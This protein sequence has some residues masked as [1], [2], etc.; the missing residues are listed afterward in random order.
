MLELRLRLTFPADKDSIDRISD[1]TLR[2]L[3]QYSAIIDN[4][5]KDRHFPTSPGHTLS[6]GQMREKLLNPPPELM[7]DVKRSNPNADFLLSEFP[8]LVSG[9]LKLA[10]PVYT[11]WGAC[12]DVAILEKMRLAPLSTMSGTQSSAPS[13]TP[14][15]YSIPNLAVISEGQTRCIVLGGL[16]LRLF[17]LGGS[18]VGH[19]M[20][21]NGEGSAT[22]AGGNG[23]MWTTALQIGEL[24]D[25]AQRVGR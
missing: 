14:S 13:G 18:V 21:D 4:A 6:L 16:R 1:R 19:K 10:V 23:T 11:V 2:H 24:I 25:T 22:I 20:F 8:K 7:A 12:E 15:E 5:A 9:E 17:G 3:V